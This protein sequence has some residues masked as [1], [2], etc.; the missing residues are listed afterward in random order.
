MKFYYTSIILALI[1]M[2]PALAQNEQDSIPS[3][4]LYDSRY[5]FLL[6]QIEDTDIGF[7]WSGEISQSNRIGYIGEEFQ[8]LRIRFLSV[9]KNFDNPYEYFFYGKTRVEE[10]LCEFQ[11]SLQITEAG[12]VK[13]A[14]YPKL[15]R[16]YIAGDYVLFE[17]Q[18]CLHSGVFRGNFIT[19]IYLD[20]NGDIYYDDLERD[21]N[22]FSNNEFFGE[23]ESYY[24][25]ELKPANWGDFRIPNSTGLDVGIEEF[26]P[27]FKYLDNGWARYLKEMESGEEGEREEE[28][29]W[30]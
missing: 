18:A 21:E 28:K 29:W 7:L 13:D 8:R 24:P 20:E 25:Y 27:S 22:D 14:R 9:I 19:G 10:N 3:D 30:K 12:F 17:D 4:S 1:F 11:G 5:D 23:W 6:T 16:A 2:L 15:T 26:K